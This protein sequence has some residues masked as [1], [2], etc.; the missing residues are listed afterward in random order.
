MHNWAFQLTEWADLKQETVG[1]NISL[2]TQ[3]M[4]ARID[5]NSANIAILTADYGQRCK[6]VAES[7]DERFMYWAVE[8][9]IAQADLSS[10]FQEW[11][12]KRGLR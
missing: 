9:G 6:T 8:L 12:R 2:A 4:L 3:A 5:R 1:A 10:R 11:K 7:P